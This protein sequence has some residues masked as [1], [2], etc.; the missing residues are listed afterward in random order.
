[1]RAE[2]FLT[3]ILTRKRREKNSFFFKIVFYRIAF[4]KS[5]PSENREIFSA[6]KVTTREQSKGRPNRIA[7]WKSFWT[8]DSNN[9]S[10]CL[11]AILLSFVVDC[12]S[13]SLLILPSD[14]TINELNPTEVAVLSFSLL[15]N[16]GASRACWPW[17]FFFVFTSH[18]R[19]F[20]IFYLIFHE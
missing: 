8:V 6:S 19:N 5:L 12:Y 9:I 16:G 13:F 11:N 17:I 1:M 7:F 15:I 3:S 20:L 18:D 10:E 4:W 14:Q 2:M